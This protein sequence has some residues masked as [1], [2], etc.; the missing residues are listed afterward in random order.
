MRPKET[1]SILEYIQDVRYNLSFGTFGPNFLGIRL[2]R[3]TKDGDGHIRQR[4]IGDE[5]I[6]DGSHG[7]GFGYDPNDKTIAINGCQG[8]GA[9]D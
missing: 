6:V 8:S 2:K 1:S 5:G 4:Q 9:V 7:F 3:D